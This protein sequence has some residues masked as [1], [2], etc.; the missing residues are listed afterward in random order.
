[1]R[2]GDQQMLDMH[3]MLEDLAKKRPVFHS[4]ADLQH[5]PAREIRTQHRWLEVRLEVPPPGPAMH[6]HLDI[7][8]RDQS[9]ALLFI[10]VKYKTARSAHKVREE[11]FRLRDQSAQDVGRYAFL[12]DVARLARIAEENAGISGCAVLLSNDSKYWTP[13]PRREPTNDPA[14]RLS[15]GRVVEGELRWRRGPAESA[16]VQQM[17][18]PIT[19]SGT[20]TLSWRDYPGTPNYGFRY[21]LVEVPGLNTV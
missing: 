11:W 17:Y 10:E 21:L 9:N 12:W 4:E 18:E 3:A 2:A 5:A 6:G 16:K 8:V 7:G 1:M 19:L 15:E 14:F 20:Y 13:S